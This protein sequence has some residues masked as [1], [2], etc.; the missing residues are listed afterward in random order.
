MDQSSVPQW[1]NSVPALEH[2]R[3]RWIFFFLHIHVLN[4]NKFLLP[5]YQLRFSTES[6]KDIP[7][8]GW[9]LCQILSKEFRASLCSQNN[10]FLLN[11]FIDT[12]EQFA[13]L[14][15]LSLPHTSQKSQIAGDIQKRK[16]LPNQLK[17]KPTNS[18]NY[19]QLKPASYNG[20]VRH[21]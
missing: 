14:L 16:L 7:T 17:F 11:C 5:M 6:R 10:V 12:D 20:N 1:A 19:S 13:E 21:P 2:A 8:R 15:T 9:L 3:R 18:W 4:L